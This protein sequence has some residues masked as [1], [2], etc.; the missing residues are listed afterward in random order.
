VA[1][2]ITAWERHGKR[3]FRGPRATAGFGSRRRRYGAPIAERRGQ[4]H[5]DPEKYPALIRA[6]VTDYE[7]L[8]QEL[9]AA[10]RGTD[11]RSILDL[12]TGTG[13]TAR[14]VLG[15][16][17]RARLLGLDSSEA[18]LTVA[19]N[20]LDGRRVTLRVGRLENELPAGPFDLCVSALAV[21]HLDGLRKR[22][23]FRRIASVLSPG[24]RFVMADVVVPPTPDDAVTPL[25]PGIDHPSSVA[26]QLSWLAAA[27]FAATVS[28]CRGD[29]A[30]VRADRRH[31]GPDRRDDQ[32]LHWNPA[33]A[34]AE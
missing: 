26:E 33:A 10:T 9:V 3:S 22:D 17:P 12:G 14:R 2:L 25:T 30:V 4:F 1:R 31:S 5:W 18:M 23:L 29:L 15:A 8:Q 28:W 6:E 7:R 27:G 32:A 24:G 34:V 20:A 19:R 16:H 21:H 13:E 11:P